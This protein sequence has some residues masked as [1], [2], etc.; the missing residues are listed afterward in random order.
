M[1]CLGKLELAPASCLHLKRNEE[2]FQKQFC[3]IDY[4]GDNRPQITQGTFLKKLCI[5]SSCRYFEGLKAR[6]LSIQNIQKCKMSF[7]VTTL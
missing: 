5:L 1:V 6:S 4:Q 7:N 3:L 2:K